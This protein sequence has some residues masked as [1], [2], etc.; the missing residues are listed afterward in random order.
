MRR[1]TKHPGSRTFFSNREEVIDVLESEG[2]GYFIKYY[3]SAEDMP[4]EKLK[5]LFAKAKK[6]LDDFEEELYSK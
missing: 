6:A 1:A 5:N 2:I 4:D 3:C